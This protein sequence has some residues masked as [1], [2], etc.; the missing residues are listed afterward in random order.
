MFDFLFPTHPFGGHTLRLVA[1]AQQG[2][3]DLFDIARA[4]KNVDA[5]DKSAW[6]REW[7]H[8]ARKTESRATQ[9]LAA[10]HQRTAQQYFFHASNYYRMSDA[11]LTVAEEPKRAERF[12][13]AREN[14]RAA[15]ELNQPPIEVVSIRCG[16]ETYDGYF[17]HPVNPKPGKW[18][19]VLFLGGADAYAEEIY[20]AGKQLLDRGWA[21]LLADTPGRGSSIYLKGIK[22][23]PDYEVPG[24]ACIDYLIERPEVDKDRIALLGI[25]MAGY[26]A[27]RVA[28]YESRLKALVAWSGCY[29]V[30]DDLYDFCPHLQPVCQRLLGG[31]NHEEARKRLRD[32]TL[33]GIAQNI[34]CPTLI[35]HGDKDI[36]MSVHGAIRLFEQIGAEDKTLKI[37][38]DPDD[39]GRIHCSH[40]YWAHNVPFMLDWLEE[41][42]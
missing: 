33:A 21:M 30:L 11:L 24:K 5:G 17:C 18:P 1:Q 22:T 39:G 26:Y 12:C 4:M 35:T 10:G 19:A 31:V 38:D 34:T 29:S 23:R 13:K 20:F 6:E 16:N 32:F 9:A 36:L 15:A 37:Y 42:L 2:G 27:P 8:L 3:G 25:S 40:D 7:L 41:R 28:A 14:F